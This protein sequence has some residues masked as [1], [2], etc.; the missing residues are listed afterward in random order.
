MNIKESKGYPVQACCLPEVA[1]ESSVYTWFS[2]RYEIMFAT[3]CP[4]RPAT[5][6]WS[7]KQFSGSQCSSLKPLSYKVRQGAIY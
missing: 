6:P 4:L 5:I 2:N 7:Y 1:F 3:F